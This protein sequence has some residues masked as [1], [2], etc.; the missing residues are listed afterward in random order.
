[1]KP[2]C[3][4]MEYAAYGSMKDYL[5][6]CRRVM[7]AH[8]EGL[9]SPTLEEAYPSAAASNGEA[10]RQSMLMGDYPQLQQLG[11]SSEGND[12]Q[13][14]PMVVSRT[15]RLIQ[16]LKLEGFAPD[17]AHMSYNHL[18]PHAGANAAALSVYDK[19]YPQSQCVYRPCLETYNYACYR[20]AANIGPKHNPEQEY[21]NAGEGQGDAAVTSGE[22]SPPVFSSPE[23]SHSL[24]PSQKDT[25]KLLR[26]SSPP[27]IRI[28][29]GTTGTRS[30]STPVRKKKK[31]GPVL[32]TPHFSTQDHMRDFTSMS[33]SQDNVF[34]AP[35]ELGSSNLL[36]PSKE[37]MRESMISFPDGYIY[38]PPSTIHGGHS[39]T[40][41]VGEM[42]GAVAASEEVVVKK[43]KE[44][45]PIVEDMITHLDLLDFALQIARG[46]DHLQRM[47]VCVHSSCN[48][49]CYYPLLLLPFSHLSSSP[50]T[51]LLL[52]FPPSLPLSPSF[53]TSPPL[54]TPPLSLSTSTHSAYIVI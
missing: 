12:Y 38:A 26:S 8:A 22:P 7:Q 32:S 14:D 28:T 1:M 43:E 15:R 39:T 33:A 54:S 40:H 50:L 29:D 13:Y 42:D 9:A 41:S 2:L 3:I 44:P 23:P 36:A 51:L 34:E 46:M 52:L 30:E 27:P 18:A 19:L 35:N 31:V 47:Q 6:Y 16:M 17:E 48:L 24:S 11:A 4:L 10:L 45:A 25:T 53:F 20:G 37:N 5:A 21:Y 49:S